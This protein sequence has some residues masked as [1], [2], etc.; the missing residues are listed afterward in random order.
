MVTRNSRGANNCQD[1][2]KATAEMPAKVGTPATARMPP[3]GGSPAT[4]GKLARQLQGSR[5]DQG[6]SQQQGLYV[7]P[8]AGKNVGNSRVNSNL[9]DSRNIKDVKSS[10]TPAPN[11]ALQ[12]FVLA[13]KRDI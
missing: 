1:L 13:G 6:H 11:W 4:A 9:R 10:R 3:L 2:R 7:T 8:T 5:Q 12:H